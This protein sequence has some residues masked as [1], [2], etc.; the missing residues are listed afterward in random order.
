MTAIKVRLS[1][2]TVDNVIY[3]M[4]VPRNA[5]NMIAGKGFIQYLVFNERGAYEV[6]RINTG[7]EIFEIIGK[8]EDL[9]S[10]QLEEIMP[11]SVKRKSNWLILK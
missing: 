10:K 3:F 2:K 4:K 8:L 6:K 5:K 1:R 9:Y 7:V 11:E